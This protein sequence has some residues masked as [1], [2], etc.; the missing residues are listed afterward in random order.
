MSSKLQIL[1]PL[2]EKVVAKL[3]DVLKQEKTEYIRD[4]AIQR[5]EC[6]FELAWKTLKA[7]LEEQGVLVYSP[8]DSLRGAFQS[9]LINED[10]NWLKTIELRNLTSHTYNESTTDE[11]YSALPDILALY[12]S[13]VTSLKDRL[14]V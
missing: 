4:S 12:E 10:P 13:L 6:T 11:I 2:F 1:L 5:F 8:R 3:S 9:G 7:Y 14:S